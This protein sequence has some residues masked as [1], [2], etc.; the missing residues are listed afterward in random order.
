MTALHPLLRVVGSQAKIS[1]NSFCRSRKLSFC[2]QLRKLMTE[3]IS[4]SY[5]V[6][7]RNL[8]CTYK[9]LRHY[10]NVWWNHCCNF[11]PAMKNHD[12]N[13]GFMA[14]MIERAR[15]FGSVSKQAPCAQ[16]PSAPPPLPLLSPNQWTQ[17]LVEINVTR[18][19]YVKTVTQSTSSLSFQSNTLKATRWRT[20]H[21]KPTTRS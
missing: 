18:L 20:F 13:W 11:P 17:K 12:I 19:F 15:R 2:I 5:S 9:L 3:F 8:L 4:L 7:R 1:L 6:F 10:W 21:V 14:V 16:T